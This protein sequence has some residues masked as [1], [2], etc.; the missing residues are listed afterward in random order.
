MSSFSLD[1]LNISPAITASSSEELPISSDINESKQNSVNYLTSSTSVVN[2]PPP[3][4]L[5]KNKYDNYLLK[6]SESN[7]LNNI[8]DKLIKNLYDSNYNLSLNLINLN[9]EM[10]NLYNT[11]NILEN[12]YN[13]VIDNENI[14]KF[15]FNKIK[16]DYELLK[17]NINAKET[18]NKRNIIKIKDLNKI[19]SNYRKS[20]KLLNDLLNFKNKEIL[21]LKESNKCKICYKNDINI[22]L[23][24]CKHTVLCDS[25]NNRLKS[26]N[27]YKCPICRNNINSF[28][29]IFL[30][31]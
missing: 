22:C 30:V 15:K 2:T 3:G 25:C 4:I 20:G 12:K 19:I 26:L 14:L 28:L 5:I 9:N 24:P 7:T 8:N 21:K 17:Q 27:N 31:I 10:Y 16:S 18:I 13:I 6:L 29:K 23:N 1:N 11:Y